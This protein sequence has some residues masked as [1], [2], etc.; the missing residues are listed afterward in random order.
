MMADAARIAQ[1]SIAAASSVGL[2]DYA[3]DAACYLLRKDGRFSFE[4]IA[5][6]TGLPDKTAAL[7]AFNRFAIPHGSKHHRHRFARLVDAARE[8]FREDI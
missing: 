1:A 2:S 6:E 8:Q 7:K 4:R 3:V 5:Q